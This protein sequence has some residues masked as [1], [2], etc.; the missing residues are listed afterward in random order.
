[1]NELVGVNIGK[2]RLSTRNGLLGKLGANLKTLEVGGTK[3]K[4]MAFV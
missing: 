2:D 1:M 4:D 3:R